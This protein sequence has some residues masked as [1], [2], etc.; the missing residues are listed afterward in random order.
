MPAAFFSNRDSFKIRQRLVQIP[1]LATTTALLFWF[2]GC[3]FPRTHA[4]LNGGRTTQ[5]TYAE[6]GR[7]TALTHDLLA[8]GPGVSI[9]EANRI[10]FVA[11]A[12]ARGLAVEYRASR[13]AWLHNIKVNLGLRQRGLCY[14]WAEDLFEVL[15]QEQFRTLKLH[16]AVARLNT[17]REHSGVV[18][19]A[20]GQDFSEGMVLDAWRWSGRLAWARVRSEKYP[21]KPFSPEMLNR[22]ELPPPLP[23]KKN[24]VNNSGELGLATSA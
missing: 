2:A 11:L 19:T 24:H 7:E 3:A 12:T 15:E 20:I 16:R 9:E 14:Q 8:L 21:W 10:A 6:K 5:E 4:R 1:T 23:P 13:P 22:T 17:S 18:V